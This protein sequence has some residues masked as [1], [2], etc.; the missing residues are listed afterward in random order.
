FKAVNDRHGHGIGDE[1]L[2]VVA[3]ALEPDDDTLVLRMGGEEFLLLLRGRDAIQRAEQRRQAIAA[4][5][6][7]QVP[8]LERVVTA[9]MGLIE[10]PRNAMPNATFA[11]LYERADQLLY[12]AKQAG[13]NRTMS[14]RLKLFV[15]RRTE[16]RK[17]AA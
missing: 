11:Q 9:S 12:E 2:R 8:G 5:I 3:A 13:R 17:S 15:P 10:V 14:E 4:R 7:S 16:R 6:A 1:V